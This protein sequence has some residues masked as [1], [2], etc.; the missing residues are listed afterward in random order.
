[1][2][3]NP[4]VGAPVEGVWTPEVRDSSGNVADTHAI[5]VGRYQKEGNWVHFTGRVKTS[6]ITSLVGGSIRIYGLPFTSSATANSFASISVGFS[7]GVN[8]TVLGQ[9][10]TGVVWFNDTYI[11]MQIWNTTTGVSALTP[12]QWSDDGGVMVAGSYYVD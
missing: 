8:M 6:D 7:Q 9:S 4:A 12:T 11:G 3:Y 1:M 10:I 5:Q 2:T